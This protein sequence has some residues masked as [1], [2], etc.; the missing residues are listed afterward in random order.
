VAQ[1]ILITGG[2]GFLG[3]AVARALVARGDEVVI[4][5]RNNARNAVAA[6]E[7]GC[8]AMPLD[9]ASIESVRDAVGRVRPAAIIHAAATKFVQLSEIHPHETV[10]VNVVG[11]QNV[12]RVALEREVPTVVGISTDKAAPPV[13]TLYGISKALGERV[14]SSLDGAGDTRFTSARFGNMAWSTGSVLPEW[15]RMLD[16]TGV[17]GTTGPHMRRYVITV[18]HAARIT[19]AALDNID[20]VHGGV[21]APHMRAAVIGDLLD[22]FIRRNGGTIEQLPVRPG[23]AGDETLVGESEVGW[24]R[25]ILLGGERYLLVRFNETAATPIPG[26]LSSETAERLTEAELDAIVAAEP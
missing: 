2:S 9:V 18:D 11:T 16:E 25:E 8:E 17:V 4:G 14:L 6:H 23:D 1:R 22:A 3:R 15:R 10:D 21:L 19:L 24:T 7:V 5:S 26:P 12:A 20:Q 13:R